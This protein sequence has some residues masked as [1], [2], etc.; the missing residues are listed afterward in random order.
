MLKGIAINDSTIKFT[1]KTCIAAK[2]SFNPNS[3]A[4][5][6]ADTSPRFVA[7]IN[8]IAFFIFS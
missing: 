1:H 4:P 2:G 5:K 7:S 3:T 8:N 6:I